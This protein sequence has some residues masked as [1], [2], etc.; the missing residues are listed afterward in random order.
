[1]NIPGARITIKVA[2]MK[3]SN[4]TVRLFFPIFFIFKPSAIK[5]VKQSATPKNEV[6]AQIE[7]NICANFASQSLVT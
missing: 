6:I 5:S 1:M 7:I 3:V 4:N 2:G